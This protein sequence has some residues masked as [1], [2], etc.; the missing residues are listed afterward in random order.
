MADVSAVDPACSPPS[1]FTLFPQSCVVEFEGAGVEEIYPE[2][3]SASSTVIFPLGRLNPPL[4]TAPRPFPNPEQVQPPDL[5]DRSRQ[6]PRNQLFIM[7]MDIGD[8]YSILTSTRYDYQS[9]NPLAHSIPGFSGFGAYTVAS[10]TNLRIL[11]FLA[12][13]TVYKRND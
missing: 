12:R 7:H 13:S 11:N 3:A 1:V 8:M 4:P 10:C 9:L 2:S 5:R 6:W